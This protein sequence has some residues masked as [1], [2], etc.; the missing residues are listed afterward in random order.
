MTFKKNLRLH[1]VS[2]HRYYF[3]NLVINESAERVSQFQ[4]FGVSVSR[5]FLRDVKELTF[6][7]TRFTTIE[8]LLTQI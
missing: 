1:N 4:S 3:L 7:I 2:I 5:V 8:M 6:L